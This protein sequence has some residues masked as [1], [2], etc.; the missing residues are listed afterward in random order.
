MKDRKMKNNW[1]KVL[2][3][4]MVL[5]IFYVMPSY[6]DTTFYWNGIEM[7]EYD[8]SSV[9]LPE[10]VK[11]SRGETRGNVISTGIVSITNRGERKASLSI[12]TLAHVRCDKICNS[13]ALQKWDESTG[14]WEQILRYE[15]E[16]KQEDNPDEDLTLLIN[17]IDVE[18]LEVGT[19]RAR[20][21]HA[22]YLGD[23]YEGYTSKT[24][25]IQ[26]TK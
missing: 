19:Y 15:F 5:T 22:V 24:A 9:I 3:L 1:R 21:L 20:G 25:G 18:N 4:A 6:A 26:I 8:D 14:D 2:L 10:T 11:Q 23:V 17:A 12:Q 7:Q 13:L 16:A